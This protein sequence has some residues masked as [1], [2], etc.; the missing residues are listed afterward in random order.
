M[1]PVVPIHDYKCSKCSR[2]FEVF[3]TTQ[4]AV[5]REEPDE[6]CPDC[7]S[8]KKKRLVSKQ[9]SHVLKGKW[10]KQGY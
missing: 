3:Y 8:K 10:F 4:S 9:T 7:G 6:K 1:R 5:E 2:E